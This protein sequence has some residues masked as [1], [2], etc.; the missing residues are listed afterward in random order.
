[1][2]NYTFSLILHLDNPNVYLSI[3][4]TCIHINTHVY[5]YYHIW[6]IILPPNICPQVSTCKMS[7]LTSEE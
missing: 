7:F 5:T 6:F 2:E 4:I 3:S 1:M